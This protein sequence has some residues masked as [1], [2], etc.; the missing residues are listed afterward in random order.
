MWQAKALG[1]KVLLRDEPTLI[2]A[3]RPLA[4]RLLKRGFFAG[5]KR[6]VDGYL[7]IGRLNREYYRYYGIPE[8]RLFSMP[9]AV[10]NDFFR[11]GAE[12]AA[13]SR[14]QLRRELGLEAGRRLSFRPASWNPEK[15][16][17]DLLAAYIK[18]IRT[19]AAAPPY[20]LFVGDGEQRRPLEEVAGE[21]KLEA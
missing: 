1:L 14:E 3:P 9:Y 5:M 12:R 18:L 4:K 21:L 13:A 7:A 15:R 20:L 6:W 2:S 16:P 11:V 17:A 8:E 19:K 10:D